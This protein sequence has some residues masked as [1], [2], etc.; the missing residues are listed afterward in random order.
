[1]KDLGRVGRAAGR[2]GGWKG[3]VARSQRYR[4]REGW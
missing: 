1:M 4:C 3:C 2:G